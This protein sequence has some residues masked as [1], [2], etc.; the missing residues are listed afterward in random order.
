MYRPITSPFTPSNS[1]PDI[2]YFAIDLIN[3][4]ISS[5]A[6]FNSGILVC[7][8]SSIDDTSGTSQ[9]TG[10][11]PIIQNSGN[12]SLKSGYEDLCGNVP[13]PSLLD[14]DFI[15][16]FPLVIPDCPKTTNRRPN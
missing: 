6:P 2:Q 16:G 3:H 9:P 7:F 5:T 14:A 13:D 15:K 8:N 1:S 12:Y 10:I 11:L 4:T